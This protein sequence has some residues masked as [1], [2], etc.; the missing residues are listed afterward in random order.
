MEWTGNDSAGVAAARIT[1]TGATICLPD[2][3]F[4]PDCSS[5]GSAAARCHAGADMAAL[6]LSAFARDGTPPA[7]DG[8]LS[9]QN[10]PKAFKAGERQFATRGHHL[11]NSRHVSA[12]AAGPPVNSNHIDVGFD[13]R[14]RKCG[15]AYPPRA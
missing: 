5:V 10:P 3:L 9:I 2:D 15:L 4:I 13:H 11:N 7:T 8:S 1:N 14:Y 12:L 6:N